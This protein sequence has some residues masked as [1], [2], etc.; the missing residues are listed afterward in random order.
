VLV[1]TISLA[2]PSPAN[3]KDRA[4]AWLPPEIQRALS[5]SEHM[6]GEFFLP[7]V[8]QD[9]EDG[10]RAPVRTRVLVEPLVD[11][12]TAYAAMEEAIA[13]AR[14]GVHLAS[15]VFDPETPLQSRAARVTGAS[16]WLDLLIG[17]AARG[18]VVR[19]ILADYDPFLVTDRHRRAWSSYR[20]LL[21]AAQ[22]LVPERRAGVQVICSVHGA[23]TSWFAQLVAKSKAREHLEELTHELNDLADRRGPRAA[24][25]LFLDSPGLWTSIDYDPDQARFTAKGAGEFQGYPASHHEK[26]CIVDGR[27]AFCGSMDVETRRLDSSRHDNEHPWHDVHARIGGGAVDDIERDF[28]GRWNREL[29]RFRSFLAAANSAQRRFKLQSPASAEPLT[30]PAAAARGAPGK[31]HVQVLRTLSEDVP[32]ASLPNCVRGDVE[33]AYQR[34]IGCAERFVYAESQYLRWPPFAD[35]LLTRR[36]TASRLQL[37][38]VLPVA[39]DEMNEDG[40]ADE[41]TCHGLYLQGQIIARLRDG[42]GDDFGVYSVAQRRRAPN[43]DS[44]T[45]VYGS[46][47]IYVHSKCMIVD[48]AFAI[49]GSANINGRSFR[50]DTELAIGWFEPDAV[51]ALRRRLWDEHLGSPPGMAEWDPADYVRNW[52][53]IAR[54][55]AFADPER[56]SGFVV[57]HDGKLEAAAG[58]KSR[59]IPDEFA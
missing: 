55:N 17:A 15:W 37:I 26:I 21:A 1:H 34:A 46:R 42:F 11:G 32:L 20:R 54:A 49:L 48:D 31:A 19:L 35:W 25:D 24:E 33:E 7:S 5:M 16:T 59:I 18:V 56:R 30:A 52:E 38:V 51:A 39:P 40:E 28:F 44:A 9:E 29:P 8:H 41:I 36:K 43:P 53:R 2:N 3:D 13:D 12:Q 58:K 47:Q 14:R 4:V 10:F 50:V 22:R 27:T 6:P 45:C 23:Q 57:P